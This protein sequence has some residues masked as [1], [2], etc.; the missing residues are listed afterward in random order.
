MHIMQEAGFNLRLNNH[1]KDNKKPKF[2]L[3]C[4]HFQEQGDYFKKHAQFVIID[5]LTNLH[6]SK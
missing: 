5:K 2:F 6:G 1:K 3:V 4:N